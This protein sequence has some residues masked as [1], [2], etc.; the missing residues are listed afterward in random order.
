MRFRITLIIICVSLI[1]GKAFTQDINFTISDHFFSG[2][3]ILKVKKDFNDPYVWVLGA[4]N[5]VFQIN[6]VTKSIVDY[7]NIFAGYNNSQFVDIAGRSKDTLFIATANSG[8]IQCK[9]GKIKI[10]GNDQGIGDTLSS[11]GIDYSNIATNAFNLSAHNNLNLLVATNKGTFNYNIDA[12]TSSAS[13]DPVPAIVFEATYRTAIYSG[14][15]NYSFPGDTIVYYK[16]TQN[17]LSNILLYTVWQSMHK[18]G[19]STNTIFKV[20]PLIYDYPFESNLDILWGSQFGLFQTDADYSNS[21]ASPHRQYLSG[22][23]VNKIT[24]ILGLTT[25]GNPADITAPGDI[26]NN[27]L[28]GTDNGLYFSNSV[29]DLLNLQNNLNQ[30]TFFHYDKLGN[31]RINDIYVNAATI[32]PV[33]ENGAWIATDNGLYYLVPQYDISINSPPVNAVSFKNQPD[34]VKKVQICVNTSVTATAKYAGNIVQ[35]YKNANPLAGS[36]ADTLLIAS[37]GDYYA[38]LT[39]LCSGSHVQTNHVQVSVIQQPVFSF[40]YPEQLNFCAEKATTLKVK[41]DQS[42]TYRWFFNDSF[43]GITSDSCVVSQSGKYQVDVSSCANSWTSSQEVQVNFANLPTP[44]VFADKME[45]CMGEPAT[46]NTNLV[47]DSNYRIN[48][49]RDGNIIQGDSNL[50]SIVT[51]IPASYAVTVT[52]KIGANC[53]EISLPTKITFNPVPI[54]NIKQTDNS[55]ICVGQ[56]VTLIASYLNGILKWSTGETTDK[57]I[58]NT[59]GI[60][61][62]EVTSPS[63]CV[64][65]TSVDVQFSANPVLSIKDTSIC[66]TIKQY[67]TLVAPT[68]FTKYF[69]N[70]SVGDNRFEVK[71]PQTVSLMVIDSNGCQAMQQINVIDKCSNIFIP[72]TFTPNDDGIN[73]TWVIL[74]FDDDPNLHIK[75][76]NRY[77]T[78]VFKSDGY[79]APWNG[80]LNGKKLP[81][82]VYYYLIV[83]KKNGKTYSG[84]VT[85][86]R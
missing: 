59:S 37:T 16:V 40:N 50:T 4:N 5:E 82:G 68:G 58:V 29:Y 20:S 73:D 52:S 69:W 9:G 57:I 31:G 46:L 21:E 53:M 33:C 64:K 35:W 70:G 6:N 48:W 23:K 51:T 7:T 14:F 56:S 54:V 32:N 8:L 18:Y 83:S 86:I 80:N 30:Y 3:K 77:G 72:N 65:D 27:L 45:Y 76:F 15:F 49:S 11:I 71:T 38:I 74:G 62:A 61:T 12:E 22:I 66:E 60:Y 43:N 42:Y 85:I 28:V 2:R 25:F 39:N 36:T 79:Y 34:S 81:S 63:G 17:N 47:A 24:S 41:A 19:N 13:S 10:I 44:I 55:N 78:S 84:F 1:G 75:V 67:I 26:K